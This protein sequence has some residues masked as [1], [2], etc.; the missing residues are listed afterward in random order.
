MEACSTCLKQSRGIL[1]TGHGAEVGGKHLASDLGILPLCLVPLESLHY[2]TYLV[3]DYCISPEF[4]QG[5]VRLLALEKVEQRERFIKYPVDAT[6]AAER[7]AFVDGEIHRFKTQVKRL[8]KSTPE[9]AGILITS[10]KSN[11][12][13]LLEC[14]KIP[15]SPRGAQ[16]VEAFFTPDVEVARVPESSEQQVNDNIHPS[17]QVAANVLKTNRGLTNTGISFQT[18]TLLNA[19]NEALKQF[20]EQVKAIQDYSPISEEEIDN[21]KKHVKKALGNI[22]PDLF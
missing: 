22:F 12:H 13:V 18:M 9:N 21:G 6:A 16:F 8:V 1:S 14:A 2:L 15:V 5:V 10:I 20:V 11:A 19:E 17:A 7:A 4:T 3:L